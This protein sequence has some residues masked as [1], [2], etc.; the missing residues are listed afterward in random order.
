M[1]GEAHTPKKS[2]SEERLEPVQDLKSHFP[3][4]YVPSQFQVE[5]PSGL[6]LPLHPP[7]PVTPLNL[8]VPPLK[9]QVLVP[10]STLP[11][12]TVWEPW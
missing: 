7:S 1:K 8:P 11:S 2:R 12:C 4:E 3:A 9:V 6:P 5:V 10:A